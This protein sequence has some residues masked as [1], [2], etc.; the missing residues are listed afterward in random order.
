MILI[1]IC[2]RKS[3]RDANDTV[4]KKSVLAALWSDIRARN[5]ELKSLR[6]LISGHNP[7]KDRIEKYDV[8]ELKGSKEKLFLF[9]FHAHLA[10]GSWDP[11]SQPSKAGFQ[12]RFCNQRAVFRNFPSLWDKPIHRAGDQ[13]P[14]ARTRRALAKAPRTV[15]CTLGHLGIRHGLQANGPS[16]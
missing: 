7:F 8:E 1:P 12:A 5:A 14:H 11:T 6:Q 3:L 15:R 16:G 2:I 10:F 9:G 13:G 4:A